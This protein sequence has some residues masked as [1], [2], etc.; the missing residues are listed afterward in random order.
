MTTDTPLYCEC[1]N[2]LGLRRS[3]GAFVS[4]RGGRSLTILNAFIDRYDLSVACE[5]C[6]RTT[7]IDKLLDAKVG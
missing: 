4:S 5:D 6:Q 3:D 2:R 7:R 1:G